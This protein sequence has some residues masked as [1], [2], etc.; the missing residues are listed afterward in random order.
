MFSSST[1]FIL[2]HHILQISFFHSFLKKDHSESKDPS[3][4]CNR[5]KSV[6]NYR[7]QKNRPALLIKKLI[8][9]PCS[10]YG[11]SKRRYIFCTIPRLIWRQSPMNIVEKVRTTCDV[12]ARE[13]QNLYCIGRLSSERHDTYVKSVELIMPGR[14]D[15]GGSSVPFGHRS[16]VLTKKGQF[17]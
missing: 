16:P 3:L 8:C 15:K 5:N 10:F 11:K 12:I 17:N 4:S 2:Q 7:H 6:I 13:L 14:N 9:F 1:G